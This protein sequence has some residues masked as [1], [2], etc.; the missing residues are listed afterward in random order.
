M[1]NFVV[2]W[3]C[4][5][6]LFWI[7]YSFKLALAATPSI[8][9]LATNMSRQATSSAVPSAA[10]VHSECFAHTVRT[11]QVQLLGKI[12]VGN[13]FVSQVDRWCENLTFRSCSTT[14]GTYSYCGMLLRGTEPCTA[15]VLYRFVL[16]RALVSPRATMVEAICLSMWLFGQTPPPTRT[17]IRQGVRECP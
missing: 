9:W 12:V 5:Y 16:S 17:S 3:G 15:F 6:P 1:H 11:G 4:I 8:A 2:V 13:F 10:L 14:G 7:L